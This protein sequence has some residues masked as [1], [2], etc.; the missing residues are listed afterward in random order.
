MQVDIASAIPR[1]IMHASLVTIFGESFVAML[2]DD[3]KTFLEQFEHFDKFFEVCTQR[4]SY[5]WH[6]LHSVCTAA[7][8]AVRHCSTTGLSYVQAA[9]SPLPGFLFPQ[10][11]SARAHL[12]HELRRG[13]KSDLRLGTIADSVIQ[14]CGVLK[15]AHCIA[16]NIVQ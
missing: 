16:C 11:H 5:A 9:A 10:Y 8:C 13:L 4:W 6:H 12:L 1:W 15:L 7:L 3:V 14:N 2:G